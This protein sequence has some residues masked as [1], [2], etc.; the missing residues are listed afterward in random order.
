MNVNNLTI[1]KT[2]KNCNVIHFFHGLKNFNLLVKLPTLVLI[3]YIQKVNGGK[4]VVC[5]FTSFFI[6]S[7]F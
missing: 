4:N 5:N 6:N 2:I 7:F 1:T 3:L